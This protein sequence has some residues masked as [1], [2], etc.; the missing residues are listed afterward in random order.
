MA[1][2]TDPVR[3]AQQN[4]Y[5][6]RRAELYRQDQIKKDNVSRIANYLK[7]ELKLKEGTV[8]KMRGCK[9]GFGLREFIR[10]DEHG[11]LVCWQLLSN[12]NRLNKHHQ[13]FSPNY[14]RSNQV[15]THMPDKVSGIVIDG[16]LTPIKSLIK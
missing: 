10:W 4:E 2:E 9:D 13:L 14:D 11:N 8:L 15:T 6:A 3:I 16:V 12:R 1:G 5:A 7:N